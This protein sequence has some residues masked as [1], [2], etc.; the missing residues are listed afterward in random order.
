LAEVR[1]HHVDGVSTALQAIQAGCDGFTI[2]W[3]DWFVH[4]AD[5]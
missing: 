2:N 4:E 5:N 1:A 3:P